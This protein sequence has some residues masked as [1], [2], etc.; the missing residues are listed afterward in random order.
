MIVMIVDTGH[1]EFISLGNDEGEAK[2]ALL[3]RWKKHCEMVPAAD[4]TYMQELI[5]TESVQ[6]VSLSPGSA[7]IYGM[8]G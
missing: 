7:V 6:T 1:F 8:D 5:D 3:S 4:P 2:K